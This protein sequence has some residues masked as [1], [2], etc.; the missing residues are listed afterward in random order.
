MTITPTLIYLLSVLENINCFLGAVV[1][2]TL[3]ALFFTIFTLLVEQDMFHGWNLV[4]LKLL[5]KLS[6]F[7]LALCLV[8]SLVPSAKTVIAMT[9]IPIIANNQDMQKLP[10][11]IIKFINDYLERTKEE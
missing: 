11:N 5:K 6:I 4:K 2:L 9:I 8:I 10:E 3:I 7:F 1:L